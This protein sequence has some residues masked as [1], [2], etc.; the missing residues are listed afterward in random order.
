MELI[1]SKRTRAFEFS[2]NRRGCKRTK[3][4]VSLSEAIRNE[5]SVIDEEKRE[6]DKKA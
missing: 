3:V 2:A 5:F 1:S 4:S 6:E